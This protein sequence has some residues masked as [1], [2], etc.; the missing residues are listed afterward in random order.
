MG[1]VSLAA[2]LMA[3]ADTRVRVPG[4]REENREAQAR[5]F[6]LK[7]EGSQKLIES[8]RVITGEV[9]ACCVVILLATTKVTIAFV[10]SWF[11]ALLG[12]FM[13]GPSH[14]DHAARQQD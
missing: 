14:I 4:R 9:P 8:G 1:G 2:G 5:K 11:R 10:V 13:L 6:T 3:L 12:F 7:V